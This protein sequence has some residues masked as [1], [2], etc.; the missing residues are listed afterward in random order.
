MIFNT[1][2][3]R[4][5]E[6]VASSSKKRLWALLG[7]LVAALAATSV[8]IAEPAQIREKRAEA[9]Q[10]LAQVQQIDADLELAVEAYNGATVRLDAIR[11]DIRVNQRHL[12]IARSAQAAAQKNLSSR[13]VAL[14]KSGD[15]DLIQV[16]LGSSSLG[17]LLDRIDSAKRISSLD[18]DM[19]KAVHDA[20]AEIQ[21]R[22]RKLNKAHAEQQKVVAEREAQRQ[23]IESKLTEREALLDSIK[24]QIGQLEAEEQARQVRLRKEAE[25]RLEAARRE[26]SSAGSRVHRD[27]HTRRRGLG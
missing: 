21:V 17:D 12:S 26:A 24:D 9:E 27:R 25:Q 22:A 6:P 8:A 3:S 1:I 14:Y 4:D 20:R 16:M 7:I 23:A 2:L 15:E 5:P 19:V 13:I 11:E 18:V 10:V